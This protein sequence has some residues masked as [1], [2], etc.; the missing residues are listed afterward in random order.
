MSALTQTAKDHHTAFGAFL[1]YVEAAITDQRYS[2][3]YRASPK[4]GKAL[5][6]ITKA[7]QKARP[8][9]DYQYSY[10][11]GK[12]P[13]GP[14]YY[15]D[16]VRALQDIVYGI[17]GL[18]YKY[19]EEIKYARAMGR[20]RV[21]LPDGGTMKY[22]PPFDL[23]DRVEQDLADAIEDVMSTARTQPQLLPDG[24]PLTLNAPAKPPMTDRHADLR[25]A[26]LENPDQPQAVFV[27]L[28][29]VPPQ[30]GEADKA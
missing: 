14:V 22:T 18:R 10:W 26:L 7:I 4:V 24:Q 19:Q 13:G 2:T 16:K 23:S 17:E 3:R 8:I 1:K 6:N 12:R 25:A 5:D 30:Y 20:D 21:P 27:K 29:R 11:E 15:G 28:C 9:L